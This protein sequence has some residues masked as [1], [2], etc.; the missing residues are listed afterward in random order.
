MRLRARLVQ[1]A[2]GLSKLLETVL[3]CVMTPETLAE[4]NLRYFAR[5]SKFWSGEAAA[6]FFIEEKRVLDGLGL[7]GGKALCLACGGGREAFALAE[8]GFDVLGVEQ[9]PE[10][11]E[12]CLEVA[13][14]RESKIRFLQ[15]DMRALTLDENDFDLITIINVAYSCV[16][17]KK[18]RVALLADCRRR[19]APEGRCVVSFAVR[20]PA[21]AELARRALL[22]AL[23]R[24]AG[25][26]EREIGDRLLG[27][28]NFVHFFPSMEAAGDEARAAGFTRVELHKGESVTSYFA[29]AP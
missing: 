4:L 22:T 10:L 5:D 11:V 19:L 8:R 29:A 24:V 27:E 7:K 18:A 13:A 9:V 28:G 15:S 21:E 2:F 26:P 20:A 23:S 6:G 14:Q 17:S 25:N 12:H 1:K 3:P 16:P